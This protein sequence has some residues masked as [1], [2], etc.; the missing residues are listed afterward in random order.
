MRL[1][2]ANRLRRFEVLEHVAGDLHRLDA[3]RDDVRRN[4]GGALALLAGE[5]LALLERHDRDDP[6]SPI[7][8]ELIGYGQPQFARADPGQEQQ[9]NRQLRLQHA[10]VLAQHDTTTTTDDEATLCR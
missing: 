10:A 8:I 9:A 2:P 4:V 7:Q 6:Q 3:Q 1:T 5:H